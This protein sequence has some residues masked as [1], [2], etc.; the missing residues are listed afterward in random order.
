[1]E[2]NKETQPRMTAITIGTFD[3]YHLGHQLVVNTLL[4]EADMR[5]L[6]PM[7]ITFSNHPMEVIAPHRAPGLLCSAAEKEARLRASGVEVAM[8]EFGR[9]ISVLTVRE[10]IR[11]LRDDF[12]CALIVMGYDNTFG[13]D[14]VHMNVSD[15]AAIGREEGVE[16]I[17]AAIEPGVSSSVIRH[18]IADGN[19][20]LASDMLGRPV[21]L[22]GKVVRGRAMGAK[23]G[24]PTA[25][26]Q[27]SYRA[28]LPYPG[29]YGGWALLPDGTQT[30]A[31]INVGHH[32]TVGAD[33]TLSVEAHLPG[34]KGDL[35]DKEIELELVEFLREEIQFPDVD[36]LK[37][38]ISEDI[39]E[40]ERRLL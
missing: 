31:V 36:A 9:H 10:M 12:K 28:Q 33:D 32:P 15:F 35:Y 40:A 37:Q 24:F 29:V 20:Q 18:A 6:R 27:P 21:T 8:I 26:L 22:R 38:A 25:N 1:M 19:L 23:L 7:A 5:G 30:M 34:F 17:E 3:G 39:A 13:S 16:V 14:G 11:L 2:R 4:G